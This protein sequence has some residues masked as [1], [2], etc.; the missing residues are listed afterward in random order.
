MYV[1]EI[2]KEEEGEGDQ[3]QEQVDHEGGGSHGGSA[4]VEE[5]CHQGALILLFSDVQY[6]YMYLCMYV[7]ICIIKYLSMFNSHRRNLL[8]WPLRQY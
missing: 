8:L 4:D 2:E 3:V 7:S 6:V 1:G 5:V